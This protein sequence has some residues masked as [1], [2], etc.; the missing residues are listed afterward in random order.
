MKD[1]QLL[2][3]ITKK[4]ES[5]EFVSFFKDNGV[6][7]WIS[8]PGIGSTRK[9]TLDMFG[10]VQTEKTCF[11][12]ILQTDTASGLLKKL[13]REMM[14]Y[15]PDRGIACTIPV[16]TSGS[17]TVKTFI[18]NTPNDKENCDMNTSDYEMIMCITASG[19]S[20]IVMD[21]ARAGG[22]G[23]GTII[24][25]KGTKPEDQGKFFGMT[26]ADDKELVIIVARNENK[27]EIMKSILEKA[28]ANTQAE[29]KLFS[30][31]VTDT[32]GFNFSVSKLE[33]TQII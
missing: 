21:A 32:A 23:G 9:E 3:C 22:A 12:T 15:L 27:V 5:N 18:D 7:Y 31:P 29:T 11:L 30:V 17:S 26:I 13:N 2:L 4:S 8:Y 16:N 6:K 25:A 10:L 24:H 33:Q 14:M 28:G 19:Y 1:I 20:D